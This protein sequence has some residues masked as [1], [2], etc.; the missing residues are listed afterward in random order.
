MKKNPDSRI[1]YNL[2]ATSFIVLIFFVIGE[3][4]IR[5]YTRFNIIYD[6]EMSK[7]ARTLKIASSNPRI[8]HIHKPNKSAFLMGVNITIN[9]DGLRD[10]EYSLKKNSGFRIIFL[11]D[12]LT[13]GWGVNRENTFEYLLERK[14]QEKIPVEILNFG[15]GNYNT[16]QEVNLFLEK[17]LKYQPDM[18]VL[19]YYINDA[20]PTP[21]QSRWGVLGQSELITFYWSKISI[22][23]NRFTHDKDFNTFYSRLYNKDQPGWK[24]TQRALQLLK[25]TCD[26]NGIELQVFILPEL[27][28]LRDY[29]FNKEH[30]K[31]IKFLSKNHI[32]HK[33][34]LPFFKNVDNPE[35]LWVALD[36][37]HPNARAHS[38]IAQYSES[39][40]NLQ[41]N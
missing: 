38:L 6:I 14:I 35:S 30:D 22:L 36:D 7:Y 13:L 3:L 18:V 41:K 28:N 37:A 32:Q 29:P 25:E 20:E 12:S 8:S 2:I 9:S 39:F 11:G 1:A 4:A 33:D 5:I 34:L 21:L 15:T 31:I 26:G 27:H 17:G 19:F 23:I 10:R 24:Q 40:L 16:D